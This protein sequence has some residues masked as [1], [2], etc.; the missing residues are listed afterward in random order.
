AGAGPRARAGLMS[1]LSVAERF[2]MRSPRSMPRWRI[3]PPPPPSPTPVKALVVSVLGHVAV[4]AVLIAV[5]LSG[6]LR[7][8]TVHVVNLFPSVAAV[9]APTGSP[10]AAP[11][12]SRGPHPPGATAEASQRDTQACRS[13]ATRAERNCPAG[14]A[15]AAPDAGLR[16]REGQDRRGADGKARRQGSRSVYGLCRR[17]GHH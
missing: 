10:A 5:A 15:R 14:R 7:Q 8:P 9:G 11:S 2:P 4:V 16:R 12:P 1:A 17:S 6:V 3:S 13:V